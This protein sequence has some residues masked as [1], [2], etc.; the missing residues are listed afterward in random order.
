MR[1]TGPHARMRAM[2]NKARG[3][4]VTKR[5]WGHFCDLADGKDWHIKTI[6]I[7]ARKRLS[8]QYHASRDEYWV[9]LEGDA[10][11]EIG[12]SQKKLKTIHLKKGSFHLVSRRTLHRLASKKGGTLV[13]ISFGHFDEDDIIRLEDDFGRV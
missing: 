7:A 5:P 3:T 13:E 4:T 10:S 11:A 8:L 1:G 2:R 9:L 6:T 12:S